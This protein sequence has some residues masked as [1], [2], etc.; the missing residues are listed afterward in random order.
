VAKPS[1][2]ALAAGANHVA[3]QGTSL[4]GSAGAG[5]AQTK[6][7]AYITQASLDA[8]LAAFALALKSQVAVL[9]PAPASL[10]QNIAAGGNADNPYAAGQRINT[11]SNVTVS[12]STID[13]ASIPDLS[14][15]YLSIS[16]TS[17]ARSTLGLG[18]AANSDVG[19]L[20]FSIAAWGDSL[21]AGAYSQTPY[22]TQLA[23]LSNYVVYNGGVG[24][25]N[26]SLIATN[27]LAASDKY[28]WPTIIWAGRND[29]TGVLATD[30]PPI[31]SNIASMVAALTTNHYLI[32]GIVNESTEPTGTTNYNEIVQINKDLASTY[33][34]HFIDIRSYLV[35]LYDTTQPQDVIDYNNDVPPSSLRED[36]IH[37][38]S[39]GYGDVASKI[40]QNINTLLGASNFSNSVITTADLR[41][42]LNDFST[43]YNI[44]GTR[45]LY[46][47]STNWSTLVGVAAGS[48]LLL[49]SGKYNTAVGYSA[50]QTATSSIGN[51]AIGYKALF[52]NTSGI[53]NLAAGYG[54][55]QT[56]TTGQ[57]NA[58]VGYNA[59]F[60]Q[61][62]GSSNVAVGAQALLNNYT[63]SN[64]VALGYQA[65]YRNQSATSSVAV[66]NGAGLG[67]ALYSNQGGV[68][69]GNKSAY[70]LSSGSD[71]NTLFGYQSGYGITTGARNILLG[72]STI[73]TSYNQITT[74][75]NNIAI[76][77]DVAVA[78]S[79]LSN[80]LVI[81]N[82]VYGTGLSGTGAT[83]S[84][85]NIGIASTTPWARLSI[86]GANGGT[87]PMFAISTS[88]SGGV[89]HSTFFV[90]QNGLVGIGTSAPTHGLSVWSTGANGYFAVSRAT[91]GD[92]FQVGTNGYVGIGTTSPLAVLSVSNNSSTAANTPLFTIAST[93]GGTAT[94]TVLSVASTGN[95]TIT[96]SAATCTLGNGSSATNCSSSD[97]RLKDNITS[98]DASSSLAAIRQLI[99][100][101][102][103]WNA[104][105]VGN[106]SPTTTQYGFIAQQVAPVFSNLVVQDEHTGY[107]KLDYQG[108]FAPIVG[109]IQAL[110]QKLSDMALNIVSAHVTATVGD[111]DQINTKK[112][113]AD[114]SDGGQVCVTGDQL[115]NIL[116]GA[117]GSAQ[118]GSGGTAAT[119]TNNA[120]TGGT[121]ATDTAATSSDSTTTASTTDATAVGDTASTSDQTAATGQSA[122]STDSTSPAAGSPEQASSTPTQ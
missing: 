53:E 97:Q 14:G 49:S 60:N 50:L 22:P 42:A 63:G 99:P 70:S 45:I 47:T 78:S 51:T 80:Q 9:A 107:F 66:G 98:L 106:G 59:L 72:P 121:T 46:A 31:L 104:W 85:G 19:A 30:E 92:T 91:S 108:L 69:V 57:L 23:A 77:N 86:V 79:T 83:V 6:E 39:A 36:V 81:G 2:L 120:A 38:T 58:A 95:L 48:N 13:T 43:G 111:F 103:N 118:P 76:G 41:Q 115:A 117:G 113:C 10:P 18:Y 67:S 112:L 20:G 119:A 89:A 34:Q 35:S 65:L 56:N 11:L 25:A 82:L 64:N 61:S 28:S 88:T 84:T 24:G 5:Q 96:G 8:Q 87:V 110:A 15:S 100:V 32:L 54:S 90:D 62:T 73:S 71:Y 105:M 102:F 44:N 55:L 101:S 75:S 93:T 29:I 21:T 37:L 40:Y 16:S 26:S 68:Y 3:A 12:N 116:T 33:G 74:G 94:T 52:S 109:A 1:A 4:Y 114:K 7:D 27:M 122:V 17:T